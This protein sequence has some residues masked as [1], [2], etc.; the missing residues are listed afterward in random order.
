MMDAQKNVLLNG[1]KYWITFQ[2]QEN[3]LTIC[4]TFRY[5]VEDKMLFLTRDDEQVEIPQNK[6]LDYKPA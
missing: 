5:R 3:I 1:K 6:I 4:L 2:D